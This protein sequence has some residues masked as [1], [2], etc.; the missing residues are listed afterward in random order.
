MAALEKN[1]VSL[2]GQALREAETQ[3]ASLSSRYNEE[4][5]GERIKIKA[6]R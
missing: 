2:K 1:M 5:C 3:L 4:G 6:D